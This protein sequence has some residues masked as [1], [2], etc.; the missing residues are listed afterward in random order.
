[1]L[2]PRMA[3]RTKRRVRREFP[4]AC[5]LCKAVDVRTMPFRDASFDAVVCC[6]LLELLSADD[7]ELTVHEFARVLRPSGVLTLILIG[8]NKAYFNRLY[9]ICTR[10]APAFWGRQVERLIPALIESAGF[11]ISADRTVRQTFYPSRILTAA[12]Y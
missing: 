7:I 12:K 8:Q 9:W 11:D 2:S 6:Y 1:D 10:V 5:T 4:S 3:A